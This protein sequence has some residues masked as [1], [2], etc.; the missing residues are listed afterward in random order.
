MSPATACDRVAHA[1]TSKNEDTWCA[2]LV[3]YDHAYDTALRVFEGQW[4][5]WRGA[6][7]D[8]DGYPNVFNVKRN[9][10]GDQWLNSDNAN[11]KN[12]W[13]L[14][15]RIVFRLRNLLHFPPAPLSVGEFCLITC[16]CQPPSILPM[17]ATFSD[18]SV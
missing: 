16:P 1:D 9:D 17:S 8:S 5:G 18:R 15:Y 12:Q 13:S 11:P 14:D 7:T 10:G 6:H 3:D 2:A 4:Y